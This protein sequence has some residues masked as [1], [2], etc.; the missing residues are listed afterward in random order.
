MRPVFIEIPK[1]DRDPSG[2]DK[3]MVGK[4]NLS[5]YG[6]RDA[7]QNVQKEYIGF[8]VALGFN[9]GGASPCNC[10]HS[11]LDITCAVHV[12][13]SGVVQEQIRGQARK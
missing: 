3:D 11:R 2:K 6:T 4:L 13:R 9:V 7:A 1:E 10:H 5:L 12:V 8:M